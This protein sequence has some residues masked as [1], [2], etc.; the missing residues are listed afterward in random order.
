MQPSA[1][2]AVIQGCSN[3]RSCKRREVQGI[4]E[5]IGLLLLRRE[6]VNATVFLFLKVHDLIDFASDVET[7][8]IFGSVV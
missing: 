6:F 8:Y 2:E 7:V 4:K 1:A 3:F 5:R